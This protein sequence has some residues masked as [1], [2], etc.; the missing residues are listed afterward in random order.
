MDV[1]A[2][3]VSRSSSGIKSSNSRL[4]FEQTAQKYGTDKVTTHK[5]QFMYD[6][7]LSGVREEEIKVLEIGL[8]CNM[9]PKPSNYP[10]SIEQPRSDNLS[11]TQFTGLRPRGVVLH[12]ARISSIR[13]S[14]LHRV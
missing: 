7:Y 6:K 11:N 9:V 2:D 12:L 5:Y 13:R 1:V 10:S 8:G 4:S 14:L 3:D